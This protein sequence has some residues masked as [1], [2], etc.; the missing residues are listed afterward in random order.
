M[1]IDETAIVR[2]IYGN[3]SYGRSDGRCFYIY[4][5]FPVFSITFL[6]VILFLLC[7]KCTLRI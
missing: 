2:E 5:L 1:K 7:F 3:N 4:V 6:F